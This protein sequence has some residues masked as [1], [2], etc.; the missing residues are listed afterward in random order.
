M[1]R[2]KAWGMN[3][4]DEANAAAT[5]AVQNETLGAEWSGQIARIAVRAAAPHLMA[6]TRDEGTVIPDDAVEAAARALAARNRRPEEWQFYLSE[7]M[8]ALE[9]AAPHLMAAAWSHGHHDGAVDQMLH[10]ENG[11]AKTTP[12]PYLASP[13]NE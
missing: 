11:G 7:A 5:K 12:N 10:M 13:T 8:S 6:Q 2:R 4:P 3:I 9:A 1:S